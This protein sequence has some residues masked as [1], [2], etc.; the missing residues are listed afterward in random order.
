MSSPVKNSANDL[1]YVKSVK[2]KY[3]SELMRKPNVLGIGIGL[4]PMSLGQ[5][6]QAQAFPSAVPTATQRT[7]GLIVNMSAKPTDPQLIPTEL[8]GVPVAVKETKT[9]R[10]W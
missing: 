4:V 7:L 2:A 5:L 10:A 1:T 6:A 8:D 3:E 9:I